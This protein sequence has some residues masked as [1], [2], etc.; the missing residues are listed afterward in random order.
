VRRSVRAISWFV[1]GC[2]A[3]GAA[4]AQIPVPGVYPTKPVRFVVPFA[5]G[6][7]TDTLARTMGMKLTDALG[8]QVVVDNR[9][10]ANGNIGMQI[11]ARAAPDG[12]TIVLGYIANLA[13]GPSLYERLPFDPITDFAPI[14]Q[15][16]VRRAKFGSTEP[17]YMDYVWKR[18][19]GV[20]GSADSYDSLAPV[21]IP[22]PDNARAAA[23]KA[24]MVETAGNAGGSPR[25]S[26]FER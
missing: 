24:W 19:D 15:K 3:A 17:S 2:A 25:H 4:A 11:V 13:I 22:A 5:P 14:T 9:P 8:Q 10:G 23:R 18:T 20:P 21:P 16:R 7:S 6:G 1:F 26:Q 12:H